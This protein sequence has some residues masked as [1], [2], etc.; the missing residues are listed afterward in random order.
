MRLYPGTHS[1]LSDRLS[2]LDWLG[3]EPDDQN[4]IALDTIA[5]LATTVVFVSRP[6]VPPPGAINIDQQALNQW[7][8]LPDIQQKPQGVELS[9]MRN[10]LVATINPARLEFVDRSQEEPTRPDF[11]NRVTGIADYIRNSINLTFAAVGI[12][13]EVAAGSNSVNLPSQELQTFL[14]DDLFE[15][16]RYDTIG[17]SLRVWYASGGRQYDLRVEPMENRYEAQSYYGR[18]HV[19]IPLATQT[20]VT[21]EWLTQ[22]IRREYND[23]K[24]VLERINQSTKA[25]GQ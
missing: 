5:N 13:F 19:H 9:S 18:L 25:T 14:K 4:M 15:G 7:I 24:R 17:A 16:T 8:E 23:L 3:L 22:A 2:R 1:Y 11:P 21:E 12:T 20:D 6:L 10:Q